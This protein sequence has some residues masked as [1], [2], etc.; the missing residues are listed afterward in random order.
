MFLRCYMHVLYV[1]SG[2]NLDWGCQVYQSEDDAEP[3]SRA[4]L[5]WL[6]IEPLQV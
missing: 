5:D 4:E 2:V 3:F 6:T 1:K